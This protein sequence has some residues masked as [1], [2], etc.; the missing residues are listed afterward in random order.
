[1]TLL[2]LK[3]GRI[4]FA[5][6]LALALSSSTAALAGTRE[7][8][9][10][11]LAAPGA[12]S[13]QVS[14][15][16]RLRDFRPAWTGSDD[17]VAA[18]HRMIDAM[19]HAVDYGLPPTAYIPA[20]LA[21]T[22]TPAEGDAAAR[23][24]IA[25]T[26]AVFR[27]AADM[28]TGRV[29][30]H[31][32]Y[33]EAELPVFKFNYAKALNSDL[34]RDDVDRFLQDL[35]PPGDQYRAL[36]TALSRY[37]TIA[38]GGGWPKVSGRDAG[39]LAARLALEDPALAA[40]ADPGAADIAQAILRY[41]QR[42]GLKA[43]GMVSAE[44]I[45]ALNVP[46]AWRI[47]QIVANL[48]RHRWLPVGRESTYIEVNVADQS[49]DFVRD[50]A[51]VL[52]SRVVVGTRQTQT[53]ILRTTVA[54]VVVNP[55]WDIPDT[56]AAKKLLPRLRRQPD[57]LAQ[58]NMTLA[59]GPAGDPHGTGID[60][61]HVKAG[62][63]PYQ[64]LQSP[65]ADN[66]LG[67]VMLDM[68]NDFDVYMHDTPDKAL[69]AGA[70]RQK[71][72]GC[73]RVEQILPLASLVLTGDAQSQTLTQAIAGGT[74]QRLPLDKPMPVYLMYWTAIAQPDGTV[75]F[76]SD[77]YDRDSRLVALLFPKDSPV[78][79]PSHSKR[80]TRTAAR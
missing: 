49:A 52:H 11:A 40:I 67:T 46:V 76:R 59:G 21:A 7:A 64:I 48:E 74:T 4:V 50:G 3:T 24:D 75:G 31:V 71:S 5:L 12:V 1:M 45:A 55:V 66:A 56:I 41:Q 62:D 23:Y 14:A 27:F 70:M 8:L 53:P 78:T 28:H 60:W 18:A 38:Q 33:R 25:L 80:T 73:V 43:D 37:R 20:A 19:E 47:K 36:V 17:A 44:L 29:L 63:L 2:F 9:R 32:A 22:G 72:N 34:E 6:V 26:R 69:F 51:S 79:A 35:P 54:A 16:Y 15:F 57:Y 58:R 61:R 10:A 77:F 65:G 42:N 30:P 39:K 68:P 13:D